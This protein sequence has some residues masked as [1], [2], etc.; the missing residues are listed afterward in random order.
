MRL[1][2]GW[3]LHAEM[4]RKSAEGYPAGF[5]SEPTNYLIDLER[6]YYH[7]QEAHHFETR[8]A[9][10]F[11]YLPPAGAYIKPLLVQ[12]SLTAINGV[13]VFYVYAARRG[14]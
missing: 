3:M 6:H 10:F 5:F 12:C 13:F 4:I 14:M 8:I 11:T 2:R 1:G 9:L 7:K